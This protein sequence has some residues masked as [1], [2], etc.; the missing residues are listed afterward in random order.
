[1]SQLQQLPH[2]STMP[3]VSPQAT[4]YPMPVVSPHATLSRTP[5]G[6]HPPRPP[7]AAQQQHQD[8]PRQHCQ[9]ARDLLRDFEKDGHE[10]YNS[11]QA[12][13]GATLA[14]LGQ[15]RDIP[16]TQCLQAHIRIATAQ[17]EERSQGYNRSA[18][19]QDGNFPHGG[20]S[21]RRPDPSKPGTG[22][23][24]PQRGRRGGAPNC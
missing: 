9:R 3:R 6:E 4:S 15:L 10:V 19:S 23:K 18:S 1:M 20:G 17:V 8:E 12:N 16:A 21:P 5:P 13:L 2:P 24:N 11:P 22:A 14:E 7:D